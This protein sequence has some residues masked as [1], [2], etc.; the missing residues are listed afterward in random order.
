V[1]QDS[2]AA[3]SAT[4]PPLKHER[5]AGDAW[6]EAPSGAKYWGR[7]GAAGLVAVD[8]QRGV[9]LQHRANWSHHGG[10]WG[11]PG[12]A[13]HEGEAAVAAALREAKEEAGVPAAAVSVRAT[14]VLDLDVWTY[15]TVI[16][17]VTT[18]FEPQIA[19]AES[20]DLAWVA[21]DEVA[22]L[23][24]HPGFALSWVPL[25]K[26]ITT[27]VSV[28]V[29]GANVVGAR[30]DGWWRDRPGAAARLAEQLTLWRRT[31]I[32][33]HE[34]SLDV[35]RYFPPVY[36]VVEG[37]AKGVVLGQQAA[38]DPAL[39][40]VRAPGSGDDAVVETAAQRLAQGDVVVVITSDRE[41]RSRVE[42]LGALTRGPSWVVDL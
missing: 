22:A 39:S 30:P 34:L 17:D 38:A 27:R 1:T 10:T 33:G 15:T 19:D 35:D 40:V 32:A 20:L 31:G 2:R 42:K 25:L 7:F 23:D 28:V 24:L 6:V 37:A 21:L 5:N 12:G 16:A 4:P 29:D 26:V 8:A 3:A 9:L 36:L 41:L 11:I 13:L 18:P 14:R